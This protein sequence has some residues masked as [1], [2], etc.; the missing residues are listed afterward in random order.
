MMDLLF[1]LSLFLGISMGILM[2]GYTNKRP[3]LSLFIAVLPYI[4]LGLLSADSLYPQLEE[5][6][7]FYFWG[8]MTFLLTYSIKEMNERYLKADL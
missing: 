5:W 8:M 6:R 1:V 3:Q 7:M 2:Y 4:V